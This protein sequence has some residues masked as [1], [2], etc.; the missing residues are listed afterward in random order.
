MSEI[1]PVE[2]PVQFDQPRLSLELVEVDN[3]VRLSEAR[4]S[5]NVSGQG[6]CVAVLDTGIN[7]NHVDFTNRIAAQANF[8]ADNNGD[9]NDATD[10][11]GHGTNVTGIV[12]ASPGFHLGAAPKARIAALKVLS[13]DG[14]GNFNSIEQALDWVLQNKDNHNISVVCMS[15]GSGNNLQSDDG[16]A[17]STTAKLI[18]A[19]ADVNIAVCVAAGNDFFN[20]QSQQGMSFPAIVRETISVGAVYDAREGSFSYADGATTNESAPDRITPFS[21]RLHGTVAPDCFTDVFAPGAP[22]RSSGING[23]QGESVQHGTSQ[24]APVIT[25]VILLLQELYKRETNELPSVDDIKEWLALSSVI[26]NDG[27]DELDNVINT[28]LNFARVD[29]VEALRSVARSFNKKQLP[30]CYKKT[31]A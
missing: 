13:D 3:L 31:P 24:A 27:D 8:T 17:T 26:I 20:H 12:A 6:M 29:A 15:L 7:S 30:N 25:G 18:R 4:N 16:V 21:Q 14:S 19:L 9:F 5:F 11:N 22:V 28:G 10:G 1:K 2:A 23:P